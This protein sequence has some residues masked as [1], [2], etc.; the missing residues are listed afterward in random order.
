VLHREL[1]FSMLKPECSRSMKTE[2][3]PASFAS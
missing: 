3:N 1:A 2:L